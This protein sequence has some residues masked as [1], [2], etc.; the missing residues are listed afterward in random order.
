MKNINYLLAFFI[1]SMFFVS[2]TK[3]TQ[4][5]ETED[6]IMKIPKNMEVPD[7]S[8]SFDKDIQFLAKETKTLYTYAH[9]LHIAVLEDDKSKLDKKYTIQNFINKRID[10]LW[11]KNQYIN[12]YVETI[13]EKQAFIS[14]IVTRDSSATHG[15][16]GRNYFWRIAVFESP[17]KF[18]T[19]LTF[20]SAFRHGY[21]KN[22]ETRTAIRSF[23]LKDSTKNSGK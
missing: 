8:A 22:E 9:S 10:T 23:T 16:D 13:N 1:I 2:C 11:K 4:T 14:E 3:Q 12:S 17:K 18:F 15:Y 20:E 21:L 7:W 5:I 19:I 6:F